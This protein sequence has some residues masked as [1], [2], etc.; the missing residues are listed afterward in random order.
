M[1]EIITG[2]SGH[3]SFAPLS[4]AQTVSIANHLKESVNIV[5]TKMDSLERELQRALAAIQALDAN[6]KREGAVVKSLQEGLHRTDIALAGVKK[7]LGRTSDMTENLKQEAEAAREGLAACRE[8]LTASNTNLQKVSQDQMQTAA[9]A[10]GLREVLEKRVFL[11]VERLR[12][13]L[14]SSHLLIQQLRQDET[15]LKS[16]VQAQKEALRTTN[17]AARTARDDLTRTQTMVRMLEERLGEA[18]ESLKDTRTR[19]AA[20]STATQKLKED[21]EHTKAATAD[22]Q[23]DSKKTNMT[24][25]H[26]EEKLDGTAKDLSSTMAQLN[27]ASG[28]LDATRQSLENAHLFIKGLQEGNSMNGASNRALAQ[29]VEHVQAILHETKRGLKETNALVLPNL[30]MDSTSATHGFSGLAGLGE[31]MHV[32]GAMTARGL[33]GRGT[34]KKIAVAPSGEP[35][36]R[37]A[38]I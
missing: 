12:D 20:T 32:S 18:G 27:G 13:E 3:Q 23:K 14:N 38:L 25:R 11:D 2:A 35:R 8:G 33:S 10:D 22:L 9:T 4:H 19:L 6:S 30:T 16:S 7:D 15:Q 1:A 5:S 26:V 37:M 34:R 31:S 21:H 17:G 36:E 29:Q 24:L 28:V